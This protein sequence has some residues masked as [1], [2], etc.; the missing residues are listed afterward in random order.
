MLWFSTPSYCL[1]IGMDGV[2]PPR[3]IH[4]R[5][6]VLRCRN[7]RSDF[8]ICPDPIICLPEVSWNVWL[9]LSRS[10][11][12]YYSYSDVCSEPRKFKKLIQR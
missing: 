7:L 2:L 4:T 9:P 3:P 12:M 5:D 8:L 1:R 6:V 10:I 11:N